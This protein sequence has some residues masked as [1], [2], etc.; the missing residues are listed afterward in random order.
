MPRKKGSP[1]SLE[2][3]NA[4]PTTNPSES[5]WARP[6]CQRDYAAFRAVRD[7]EYER[8]SHSRFGRMQ[9]QSY[10]MTDNAPRTLRKPPPEIAGLLGARE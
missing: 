6:E 7:A 5:W 2:F 3:T 8:M 1:A 10:T 4:S 9:L